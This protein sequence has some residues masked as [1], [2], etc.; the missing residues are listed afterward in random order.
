MAPVQMPLP[1]VLPEQS[2]E[3]FLERVRLL[4]ASSV[5]HVPDDQRER[6]AVLLAG[7]LDRM[8][9]GD[10]AACVLE[11]SRT[12]LLLGPVPR[13]SNRRV[14]LAKRLQLWKEGAF[15]ELLVRAEEQR[16]QSE[17]LGIT[18][19][20][21]PDSAAR[22]RRA[23]ALISE[24]AYSKAASSLHSSVSSLD[25]S[26]QT[27][28]GA[29]LLPRSTRPAEALSSEA[30]MPEGP[31]MEED[32]PARSAL[33]GVRFRAMS[34]AGPSGARPEHLR[35]LVAV[36]DRRIANALLAAIDK[37]VKAAIGGEL[38]DASRWLLNSRVVFL[39]KKNSTVPRPIRV[40]ELW[41]SRRQT[42]DRGQPEQDPGDL[43]KRTPIWRRHSRRSR[44]ACTFPHS[45]GTLPLRGRGRSGHCR[46]RF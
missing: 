20:A 14:E 8:A 27:Q 16:R 18:R 1:D 21:V 10:E 11:E 9:E 5:V 46:R 36:R 7:L 19:R 34:A 4:P 17:R 32:S 39:E 26:S 33:R 29:R 22:A 38:P 25:A 43:F 2:R 23:C 31:M 41:R 13:G 3:A 28:W 44:R 30:T 6:H 24:D 42:R 37:F 45:S 15:E 12:K 35:E 40:G